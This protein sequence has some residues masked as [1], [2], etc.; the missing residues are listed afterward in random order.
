MAKLS[1]LARGRLVTLAGVLLYC[2]DTPSYRLLRLSL[3]RDDPSFGFA[4]AVWRGAMA[5]WTTALFVLY[6]EAPPLA[7]HAPLTPASLAAWAAATWRSLQSHVRLLGWRKMLLGACLLASSSICFTL[8]IARTRVT[9]VLVIIALTPLLTALLCRTVLGKRLQPHTWAACFC[10]FASVALVFLSSARADKPVAATGASD[11]LNCFIAAGAPLSFASFLTLATLSGAT[12]LTPVTPFAGCLVL[13]F[14]LLSLRARVPDAAPADWAD[15]L[16]A[17]GNGF[18]NALAAAL[19]T[20]GSSAIPAPEVALMNLLELA[21]GPFLV[22]AAVGERPTVWTVG[23]AVGIALTL[24]A[25]AAYELYLAHQ[26]PPPATTG[27]LSE[28]LLAAEV[29]PAAESAA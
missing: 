16:L 18:A 4:V 10:G 20:L 2:T 17:V 26:P 6:L 12:S 8:G 13:S 28:P 14:G 23:A 1:P 15:G 9:N 22:Y 3:P 25:N 19:L 24:G 5:V 27:L 29:E 21:V 7:Q 11:V